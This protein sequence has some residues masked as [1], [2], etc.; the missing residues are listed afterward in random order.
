MTINDPR[1]LPGIGDTAYNPETGMRVTSIHREDGGDELSVTIP[2]EMLAE[3][4]EQAERDGKTVEEFVL[5]LIRRKF[6]GLD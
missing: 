1:D 2:G 3:F 4:K 5:D 6:E